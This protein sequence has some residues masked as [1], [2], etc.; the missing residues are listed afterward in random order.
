MVRFAPYKQIRI[1]FTLNNNNNNIIQK[2]LRDAATSKMIKAQKIINEMKLTDVP[3][4]DVGKFH[5]MVK[6]A[7]YA[8]NEQGK[9]LLA[10]GPMVI[11]NHLGPSDVAFNA[12]V[13]RYAGNQA[14]LGTVEEQYIESLPH[15]DSL[16]DKSM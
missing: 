4:L 13:I 12:T 9:L 5:E 7:L 14:A 1:V 10:V 16:I 11:K 3:G 8:C 15:M 2:T 6:P